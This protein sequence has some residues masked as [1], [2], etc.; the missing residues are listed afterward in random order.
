MFYAVLTAEVVFMAKTSLDTFSLKQE[1]DL[2]CSVS[3][4]RICEMKRVTEDEME[5]IKT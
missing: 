1:H 3:G 4:D 2:T 5:R